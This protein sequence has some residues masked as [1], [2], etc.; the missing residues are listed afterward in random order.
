[1]TRRCAWHSITPDSTVPPAAVTEPP[2]Y[3]HK[4]HFVVCKSIHLDKTCSRSR[5]WLVVWGVAIATVTV[6]FLFIYFGWKISLSS[7]AWMDIGNISQV[8]D[9]IMAADGTKAHLFQG[10][11]LLNRLESWITSRPREGTRENCRATAPPPD[12][13]RYYK[14]LASK[15]P[16]RT[17]D[18][19]RSNTYASDVICTTHPH[20][21]HAQKNRQ[22]T[23]KHSL[24]HKGME[25]FSSLFLIWT[26]IVN[27]KGKT[28]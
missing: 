10:A 15:S 1:M 9:C 7:L 25:P 6:R 24:R 12:H 26:S 8:S 27:K 11:A 20:R 23:H 14:C 19:L 18:G 17:A 21:L 5:L 22:S 3:T 2:S 16:R 28:S 4:I 13:M